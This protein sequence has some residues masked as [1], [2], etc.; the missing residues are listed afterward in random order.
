[1]T[2]SKIYT[3]ISSSGFSDDSQFS[4]ADIL[5]SHHSE[6]STSKATDGVYVTLVNNNEKRLV[7]NIS[8]SQIEESETRKRLREYYENE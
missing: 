8:S 4:D 2:S 6:K 3:D 5:I 1:M 7:T